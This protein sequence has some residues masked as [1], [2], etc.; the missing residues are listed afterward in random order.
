MA[1][2]SCRTPF[3]NVTVEPLPVRV[4]AEFNTRVPAPD[5]VRTVLLLANAPKVTATPVPTFNVCV[6][7]RFACP[8]VRPPEVRFP[9]V[10]PRL[11]FRV[12]PPLKVNVP[13]VWLALVAEEPESES[14]TMVAFAVPVRAVL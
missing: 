11:T 1:S 9:E 2:P 7:A 8:K 13:N 5:L 14:P 4:A 10:V 12:E 6:P 3:V